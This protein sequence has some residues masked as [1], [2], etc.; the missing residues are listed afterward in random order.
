MQ[1][2]RFILVI[3]LRKRFCFYCLYNRSLVFIISQKF[4]GHKKRV[5]NKEKYFPN[6]CVLSRFIFCCFYLAIEFW[7]QFKFVRSGIY[8]LKQLLVVVEH[9]RWGGES[10]LRNACDTCALTSR[11][12]ILSP[13]SYCISICPNILSNKYNLDM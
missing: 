5:Q 11:Q 12:T 9:R 3:A 10:V 8:V 1:L 4:T 2:L 7:S 13:S 6:L